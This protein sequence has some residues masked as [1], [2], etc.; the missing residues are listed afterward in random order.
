MAKRISIFAQSP[1][2]AIPHTAGCQ[3]TADKDLAPPLKRGTVDH[4]HQSSNGRFSPH[5][6]ARGTQLGVLRR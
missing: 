6:G 5:S 2:T 1:G 4:A 3:I